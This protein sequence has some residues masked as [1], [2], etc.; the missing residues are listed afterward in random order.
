MPAYTAPF[1]FQPVQLVGGRHFANAQQEYPI[2]TGYSVAL[3]IGD[4]VR[5]NAA[6]FLAK[7]TGTTAPLTNGGGILGIFLGCSYTD[8]VLGKTFRQYWTA[9]TTAAD[10][11][12]IVCMDPSAIFRVAY[13]SSGVTVTG[14]T[15]ANAIGKNVAMVQNTTATTV[16]DAAVGSVAATA[17]L[18]L[19]IVDVDLDSLN[20]AGTLYTAMFVTYNAGMHTLSV[21]ASATV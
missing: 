20:A 8:P 3:R 13:V 12:G 9:S 15:R 11:V 5:L 1:G 16:S 14:L 10:A 17:T 21:A 6:G 4:T 18:P 19:K 7:E 2:Q